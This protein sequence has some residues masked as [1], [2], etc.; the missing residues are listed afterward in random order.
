MSTRFIKDSAV[1][2]AVAFA[3]F[4][5]GALLPALNSGT[6]PD[7]TL[8]YSAFAGALGAAGV[9]VVQLLTRFTGDPDSGQFVDNDF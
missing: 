2:V 8:L 6:M 4:F 1:K 7:Q 9:A 3:I 5:I